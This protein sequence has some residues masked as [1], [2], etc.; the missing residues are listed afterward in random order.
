MVRFVPGGGKVIVARTNGQGRFSISGLPSGSKGTLKPVKAGWRFTPA[1]RVV[2][3]K[4]AS[5]TGRDF[6]ATRR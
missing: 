3:I 1:K 2:S 6:T 4:G 5:L